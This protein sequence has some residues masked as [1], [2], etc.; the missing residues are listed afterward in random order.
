MSQVRTTACAEA[1]FTGRKPGPRPNLVPPFLGFFSPV[2]ADRPKDWCKWSEPPRRPGG[3]TS[4]FGSGDA[5]MN[6][7]LTDTW[8][9]GKGTPAGFEKVSTLEGSVQL[10]RQYQE[11][12]Y[13]PTISVIDQLTNNP[14]TRLQHPPL[15]Y[16]K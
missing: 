1:W 14:D 2:E 8:G 5:S 9:I 12:A 6:S 13:V 7:A 16:Y 15:R 10:P 3:K 11:T 4:T